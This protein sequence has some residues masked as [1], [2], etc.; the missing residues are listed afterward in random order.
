MKQ[1]IG[2]YRNGEEWPDPGETL[3]VPDHE[4]DDL[5]TAGYAEPDREELDAPGPQATAEA[6][7]EPTA[8]GGPQAT[9]E[10]DGEPAEDGG[11]QAAAP[12][13]VEPSP[14]EHGDAFLSG[15][16]IREAEGLEPVE[17]SPDVVDDDTITGDPAE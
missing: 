1:K 4:G 12:A 11:P 7:G 3:E 14:L 2:G 8:D 5:I 6:D 15:D 9:A 13:E 17:P 16:E 10:A